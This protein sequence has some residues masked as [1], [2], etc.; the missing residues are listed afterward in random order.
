MIIFQGSCPHCGTKSVAFEIIYEHKVSRSTSVHWDTLASC[1]Q[2]NRGVLATFLSGNG[3]KPSECL[4]NGW[5]DLLSSPYLSPA[6]P[7][8]GA[9]KHTPPNVAHFYRQGMENLGGNWDAA[10]MT[11]RKAL[12]VGLKFKFP[13]DSNVSLFERIKRASKRHDLTPELAEWAHQIRLD[14][15]DA[16][17]EEEPFSEEDAARLQIFTSLVFQYL[18]TLPGMMQEA[19]GAEISTGGQ[20]ADG[21]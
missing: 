7:D 21:T 1:G 5:T 19:R 8:T 13:E 6:P 9:P 11:F 10:G 15:N 18:F 12:D 4:Q 17:H 3:H 14:G 16:A 20:P 2:C